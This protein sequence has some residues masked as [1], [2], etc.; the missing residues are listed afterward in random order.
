MT[1]QVKIGDR[2][3]LLHPV[4]RYYGTVIVWDMYVVIIVSYIPVIQMD[5]KHVQSVPTVPVV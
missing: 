4:Y 3:K 5:V 2:I 1:G